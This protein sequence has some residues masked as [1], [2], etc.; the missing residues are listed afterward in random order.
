MRTGDEVT[1]R[2]EERKDYVWQLATGKSSHSE[3]RSAKRE[4][5]AGLGLVQV[6]SSCGVC[7]FLFVGAG[8][9]NGCMAGSDCK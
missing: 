1:A 5:E 9:M 6:V 4:S 2:E 3:R 7:V 8:L